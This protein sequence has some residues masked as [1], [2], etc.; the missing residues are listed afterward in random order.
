MDLFSKFKIFTGGFLN[1][2]DEV[3]VGKFVVVRPL[4]NLCIFESLRVV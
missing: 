4:E 2:L 1:I 3:F